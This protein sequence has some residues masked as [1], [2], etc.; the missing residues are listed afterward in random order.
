MQVTLMNA[1]KGTQ[2]ITQSSPQ[3]FVAV[4]VG[5]KPAITIVIARPFL[6]AMTNRLTNALECVVT[7]VLIRV[8]Q[9][10]GL[11]KLL[12]K[13]TQGQA[14]GIL[15]HSQANLPCLASDHAQH[16]RAVIGIGSTSPLLVGP[17]T[18][19]VK[20]IEMFIAFFPP[21]FGTTHR[22]PRRDLPDRLRF[23][24]ERHWPGSDAAVPLSS[25]GSSLTRGLSWPHSPPSTHRAPTKPLA[26]DA[27]GGLQR[28]CHCTNCKSRDTLDSGKRLIDC[29][30]SS[31][32]RPLSKIASSCGIQ[33]FR[34]FK[35]QNKITLLPTPYW[36]WIN[37][38]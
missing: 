8:D 19:W 31:E 4:G 6:S 17:T 38:L 28:S 21:R 2:E 15:H 22:L 16:R 26:P 20:W 24:C 12:D 34:H 32:I 23:A 7:L 33:N 9:R 25:C 30:A 5:F 1:A 35:S 37:A 10:I 27:V 11:G 36:A 29:D 3:T 13:L 14:F 18:G